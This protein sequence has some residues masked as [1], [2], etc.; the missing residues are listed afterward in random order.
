MAELYDIPKAPCILKNRPSTV[1][2][3]SFDDD[4]ILF[5]LTARKHDLIYPLSESVWKC[6]ICKGLPRRPY[7]LH[8]CGHIGCETCFRKVLVTHNNS[9]LAIGVAECPSCRG[10]FS[11]SDL[12]P[13][14][15]WPLPMLQFWKCI[16]VKCEAGSCDFIGDPFSVVAH[17][18]KDC[19][20]RTISCITQDCQYAGTASDV[21]EHL[22]T[23]PHLFVYCYC[24]SYPVRYVDLVKHDCVTML[25]RYV[26]CT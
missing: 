5:G 23:C 9:N 19:I 7:S 20:F 25:N 2:T 3:E 11:A 22:K 13:H 10:A 16:R 24:C 18:V 1:K 4:S 14:E 26:Q 8:G 17:E 12:L 6:Q 15:Q 21:A